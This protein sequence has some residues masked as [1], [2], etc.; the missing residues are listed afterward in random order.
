[1]ISVAIHNPK[2][3]GRPKGRPIALCLC[4]V[5]FLLAA[6]PWNFWL[7]LLS[8]TGPKRL[9]R[10]IRRHLFAPRGG[11]SAIDRAKVVHHPVVAR[12]QT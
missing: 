9:H 7:A 5:V 1:M 4:V 12:E 3:K 2:E 10:E 11:N 6:W 8:A